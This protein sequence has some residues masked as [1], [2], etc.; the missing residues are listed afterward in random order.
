MM[1]EWLQPTDAQQQS[2]CTERY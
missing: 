1:A 2:T